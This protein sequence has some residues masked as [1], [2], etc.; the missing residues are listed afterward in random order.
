[1]P[2]SRPLA[3][4]LGNIRTLHADKKPFRFSPLAPSGH[5]GEK[6]EKCWRTNVINR[7]DRAPKKFYFFVIIPD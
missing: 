3:H 1:M 4:A 5:Q 2:V 6:K 7:R